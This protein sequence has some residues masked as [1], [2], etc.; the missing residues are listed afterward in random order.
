MLFASLQLVLTCSKVLCRLL[1][2][3]VPVFCQ[4]LFAK[5]KQQPGRVDNTGNKR[6]KCIRILRKRTTVTAGSSLTSLF[7]MVSTDMPSESESNIDLVA[8]KCLDYTYE[9]KHGNH[10]GVNC[11]WRWRWKIWIRFLNRRRHGSRDKAQVGPHTSISEYD[12][13]VDIHVCTVE[14]WLRR[15]R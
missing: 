7:P 12:L 8:C 11:D 5:F 6:N 2:H 1:H 13:N 9:K 14:F 3:P 4:L 15:G 10:L